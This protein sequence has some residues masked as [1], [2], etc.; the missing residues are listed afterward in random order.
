[1]T[2]TARPSRR[3]MPLFPALPESAEA[4]VASANLELV[5]ALADLLI[6]ALGD[7]HMEGGD[8]KSEDHR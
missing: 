2:R 6:E 4:N 3:Q 1:M 8:D 7:E 5:E